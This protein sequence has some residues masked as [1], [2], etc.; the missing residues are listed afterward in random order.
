MNVNRTIREPAFRQEEDYDSLPMASEEDVEY[1]KELAD[2]EDVEA[3]HR[4]AEADRR[5]AAYE[6]D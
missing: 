6:E 1:S 2:H 5:A 3:Q 4:A